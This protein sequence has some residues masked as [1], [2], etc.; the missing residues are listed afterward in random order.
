VRW[1]ALYAHALHLKFGVRTASTE[2]AE[3]VDRLIGVG[4][5]PT[6]WHVD[7]STDSELA[8]AALV[9]VAPNQFGSLPE[10]AARDR[11]VCVFIP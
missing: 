4:S 6:T 5:S 8:R 10:G 11:A 3:V 2:L 9:V 7:A 1:L